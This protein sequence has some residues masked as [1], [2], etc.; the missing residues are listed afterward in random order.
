MGG[1]AR[2][3]TGGF[4][5]FIEIVREKEYPLCEPNSHLSLVVRKELGLWTMK[6][7]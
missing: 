4:H 7:F 1:N 3:I 5:N 2:G 6:E